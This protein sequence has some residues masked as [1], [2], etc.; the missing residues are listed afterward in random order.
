MFNQEQI[1]AK[2][3]AS[4]DFVAKELMGEVYSNSYAPPIRKYDRELIVSNEYIS[5]LPDLQNGPSS[6]IQVPWSLS[7]KLAYIILGY[8]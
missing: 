3:A 6:L 2:T 4:K 1:Q 5:S 7:N 8:H